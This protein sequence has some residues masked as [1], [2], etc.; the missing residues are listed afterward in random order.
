MLTN[1]EDADG[2]LDAALELE[3]EGSFKSSS[4]ICCVEYGRM[5]G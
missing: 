4:M 2:P 3:H 1:R 5:S